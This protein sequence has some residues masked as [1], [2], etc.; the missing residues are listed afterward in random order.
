MMTYTLR[1]LRGLGS[2]ALAL[3]LLQSGCGFDDTNNSNA[4]ASAAEEG[5]CTKLEGADIGVGGLEVTAGATT[6]RFVS[7]DAKVGSPGEYVGFTT[8]V[9]G[10]AELVVKAGTETFK[11][12]GS[13]WQHP[14][15]DSGPAVHGISNV[16]VCEC[17]DPPGGDDPPGDDEEECNDPDGCD[18]TSEDPPYVE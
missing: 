15:G 13:S 5:E 11:V 12:H 8:Q 17:G 14:D 2:P 4:A 7:W 16:E 3:V 6:V 18:N 1:L 9:G 10:E